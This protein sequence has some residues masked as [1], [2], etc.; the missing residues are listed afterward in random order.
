[1]SIDQQQQQQQ[2]EQHEARIVRNIAHAV[3]E[4]AAGL[5]RDAKF[6]NQTE[7]ESSVAVFHS[8]EIVLGKL[9][10]KGG[11]S[12][13]YEASTF[14]L[15][16]TQPSA[17]ASEMNLARRIVESTAVD[18]RG[19]ATYALKH[20]DK[21]LLQNPDEFCAA[22]ADLYV[23]AKYMSR[24]N[25]PNIL[26]LRG[27]ANGGTAAFQEGR[28]NSF[29][30]L[31][32]RLS[33]TLDSRIERWSRQGQNRQDS[34]VVK[35]KYALQ[36]ASALEYLHERRIVFRD[37]KPM[38]IGFKTD[39]TVQLFDFGLCRE[40]P[41]PISYDVEE[42]FKMSN[43]GTKRYM[44][45]EI[46]INSCYN[47]KVDCYSWAAVFY[48]MLSLEKPYSRISDIEFQT[49]VLG[50]GLRPKISHLRLPQSVDLL[51]QQAWTQHATQR[52]STKAIRITLEQIISRWEQEQEMQQQ[53][54]AMAMH[55]AAPVQNSAAMITTPTTATIAEPQRPP[56]FFRSVSTP[57]YD[58]DTM[59]APRP[60]SNPMF[61]AGSGSGSDTNMTA[62]HD[63][64]LHQVPLPPSPTHL[65]TFDQDLAAFNQ[66]QQ[67][68]L[69]KKNSTASADATLTTENSTACWDQDL[70]ICT[71]D[72]SLSSLMELEKDQALASSKRT[73]FLEVGAFGFDTPKN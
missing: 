71:F 32:D 44:A 54:Q 25:H 28:Y 31:T 2:Q 48:E 19:Q 35:S 67:T 3:E 57:M 5:T 38:N 30:I 21:K 23:E 46:Y 33:D 56:A 55:V 36:V 39:D 1:M 65:F 45:P 72:Y 8:S 59:M 49:L 16:Q 53:Q 34:I 50:Q 58:S 4:Y 10:G 51:I 12:Q 27:M 47:L 40:L 60:A 22:A 37:V 41:D 52:P 18:Y 61:A 6:L 13:V 43:A 26:K 62:W 9:L 11:F 69:K 63:P 70:S 42:T 24:F 29:F 68:I 17:A 66:Q 64:Q 7:I 73:S 14:N 20:L 15:M